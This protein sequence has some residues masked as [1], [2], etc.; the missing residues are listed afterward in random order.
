MLRLALI[1]MLIFFSGPAVAQDFGI[2]F[3]DQ[4][5]LAT[6][7]VQLLI[8]ITVLSL[9]PGLLVMI[10]CFPYIV[11]VLAIL[12]Q[13]IGL[14]QSPPNMLIVTLALFLTYFVME[15]V[16]IEAWRLGIEPVLEGQI[17]VEDGFMLAIE[18]FRGFMANR[19]DAQT[20]E[21]LAALRPDFPARIPATDAPLS[22]L[23]PSFLL[24]E[25]AKAFQIGF[26]IFLPF[27]IIDLV[28]AA[29]LMSM[30]MMMV[31]PAIVSLPFKL[32]FFVVADGWSLIAGSLV[33][34][35]F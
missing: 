12:R 9:V 21:T 28:V 30:G 1:T 14:Q 20:F 32:A 18:P 2:D 35:Y 10:T 29:I 34:S 33:Q 6:R 11:T 23:V 17:A 5:A 22:V 7:S 25:I 3:S 19:V 27:L 4:G 8:L 31:P 26:V 24:S 15:P 16:M 13:A